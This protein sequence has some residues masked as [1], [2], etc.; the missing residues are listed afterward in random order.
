[1]RV[2]QDHVPGE[3]ARDHQ[4]FRVA[5]DHVRA[6]SRQ[7]CR[8]RDQAHVDPRVHTDALRVGERQGHG[9][10][11]ERVGLCGQRCGSRLEPV[12]EIRVAAAADLHEQRVE[13]SRLRGLH[14]RGDGGRAGQRGA[15]DPE[16]PHFGV[17][18][19]GGSGNDLGGNDEEPEDGSRDHG[20]QPGR[21][22]MIGGAAGRVHR[23]MQT[24]QAR[25]RLS[26]ILRGQWD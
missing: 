15:R 16:S 13:S 25:E 23:N 7:F 6:R 17:R 4:P 12:V 14:H 24:Y 8:A 19:I 9:Q 22:A 10:R 21:M 26:N 3:R 2:E 5:V 20:R 1:M 11:I 18:R